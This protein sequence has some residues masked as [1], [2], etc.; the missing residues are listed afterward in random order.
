M[1]GCNGSD[2]PRAGRY[3]FALVRQAVNSLSADV[4]LGRRDVSDIAFL[5][6]T[7]MDVDRI[8]DHEHRGV[9]FAQLSNFVATSV[10]LCPPK[11][12]AL[13]KATRTFFSCATFGV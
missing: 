9:L 4:S 2:G 8:R 3:S 7:N 5:S 13:F 10:A 11:P 12:N 1:P 6:R